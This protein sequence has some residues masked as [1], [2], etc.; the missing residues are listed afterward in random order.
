MAHLGHSRLARGRGERIREH[1]SGARQ[2]HASEFR[3][4]A[5]QVNDVAH[6]E[7]AARA[8][9][10]RKLMTNYPFA[11]MNSD[12]SVAIITPRLS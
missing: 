4:K 3:E 7:T 12:R 1:G 9:T 10:A 5:G 11:L 8:L 2:G 6:F